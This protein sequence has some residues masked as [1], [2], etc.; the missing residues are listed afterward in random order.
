[1]S[2]KE[3][4][5]AELHAR[6]YLISQGLKWVV[7]NYRCRMGEIDLI[8]RDG[9]YLV[10]V[11]VRA[12]ASKVFGGAIASVSNSKKQ[13]LIRTA[14][15]YLVANKLQDE[16]ASRFDVLCMEGVPPS[17]TWVRNAFGSDC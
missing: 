12:R 8:M 2:Q 7:S 1:M 4:F 14:L 11:E 3:G 5:L 9:A 6:D 13:K 17:I 10:F 15:F 16:Q